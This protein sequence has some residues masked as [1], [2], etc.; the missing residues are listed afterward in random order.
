[1]KLSKNK[2]TEY[3]N[4]YLNDIHDYGDDGEH[5]VIESILR[6]IVSTLEEGEH[7]MHNMLKE[8]AKSSPQ[9][10]QTVLE[11]IDYIN[12]IQ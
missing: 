3:I 5:E 8:T 4:L 9:H 11:F 6:P 12:E 1:M 10:K 7:D 2:L